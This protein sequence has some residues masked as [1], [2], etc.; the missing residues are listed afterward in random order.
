VN[1]CL[2]CGIKAPSRKYLCNSCWLELPD[3][4]RERLEDARASVTLARDRLF[5][6]L[7]AIRR[8]VPLNRIEVVAA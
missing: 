1:R 8:S 7:S 4:T 3:V 5:Q 6:L 2:A